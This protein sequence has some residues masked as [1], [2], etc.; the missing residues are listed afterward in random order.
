MTHHDA[1][2]AAR[3]KTMEIIMDSIA[4]IPLFEEVDA[5]SLKVLAAHMH[6]LE[7]G[8]G[9]LVFEEGEKGN[10][11]AFVVDGELAV[12]KDA[13]SGERAVIT[14]L[15]RGAT[16]G[17]MAV[18]DH[19]P[20]SATVIAQTDATLVTLSSEDFQDILTN[21]PQVGIAMLKGMARLLS[22]HLRKT[23]S[24][25]ADYMMPLV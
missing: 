5:E 25:L 8:E 17:E 14:T 12:I 24:Q 11:M 13:A 16:I 4:G 22:M 21:F 3:N 15:A 1:G 20:R 9:E 6:L 19:F 23:S 10:Y 2:A 18:I 7:T